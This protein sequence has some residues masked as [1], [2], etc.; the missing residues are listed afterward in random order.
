M[1]N[2]EITLL[3]GKILG[4]I[5]QIKI[6]RQMPIPDEARVFGLLNGFE[7]AVEQE[8]ERLGFIS[9]EKLKAVELIL[10]EYESNPQKL[11]EFKG[12]YDIESHLQDRDIDRGEAITILQYLRTD[13]RFAEV[14]SKMDSD[15]S[16]AECRDFN[17]SPPDF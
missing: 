15:H 11:Q 6:H 1:E 13:G 17:V 7:R 14:I 9:E 3:L 8:I 10:D 5:Y 2:R 12:Y 16:P 4:E